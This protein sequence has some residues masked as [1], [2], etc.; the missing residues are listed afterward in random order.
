MGEQKK[1]SRRRR[2]P[3]MI[4]GTKLKIYGCIAMLFYS[5]GMSVIRNGLLH[6]NQYSDAGLSELLKNNSD[7]MIIA[8]WAS[9]FQLI[10]GL[11]VPVFAFLLVEGFVHTS[12]FKKYLLTIL[13]FAVISEIPYD[14][15]MSQSV[16][17]LSAQNPLFTLTVCLIMLYGLRMFNDQKGVLHRLIQVMIVLAALLWCSICHLNF[18]LCTVLLAAIY[19]L[20]Y[21]RRGLR[22]LIGCFVSFM[23]VTGPL[24]TYA[25]WSYSGDRGWNKNKYVFYILYPVHLIVLAAVTFMLVR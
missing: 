5:V 21:D 17:V 20:L 24:S 10:G 4:T 19:Y 18:G 9:V 11:A 23:Y 25:L 14:L 13:A 3:L 12:N 16:F 7:K 22:L 6:V 2:E 15:A 8:G 1:G